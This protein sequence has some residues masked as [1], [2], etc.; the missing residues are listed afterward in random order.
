MEQLYNSYIKK[1]VIDNGLLA[2]VTELRARIPALI[3]RELF[4]VPVIAI[5]ILRE[6][7]GQLK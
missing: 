6:L 5:F 7:E 1:L 2:H 4:I 3:R